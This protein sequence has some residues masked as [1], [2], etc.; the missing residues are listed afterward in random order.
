MPYLSHNGQQVYYEVHGDQGP[1]LVALRGLGR[2]IRH[3]LG[4]EQE[5]AKHFRVIMVELRGIGQSQANHGLTDT[6]Y[7]LAG[8]VAAVVK[9]INAQPAHILGVSL[10][11]MV[12]IALA[13]R[14]P[15]ICRSLITVNTSIAGQRSMRMSI[16]AVK[17]LGGGLV[18]K[19]SMEKRLVD[20]LVGRDF[21]EERKPELE[22][23]YNEIGAEYGLPL[24]TVIR[25]LLSAA[26]FHPKKDLGDL[27]VPALVIYGTHD[28][29]T[30]NI[31]S[32]KLLRYLPKA[33]V[34][35]ID[36]GGHELSVDKPKELMAALLEWEREMNANGGGVPASD[37]ATS[38]RA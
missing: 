7:D 28:R 27:Q 18:V 13:L 6:M 34:V 24:A 25:Q 15:E 20:V 36:G 37:E 2:S 16:N 32:K 38:I 14:H 8:D 1:W 12:A 9:E 3:W 29:F 11:G 22:A 35:A 5:M 23:A 4:Y 26:R 21:P 17:A 31:N 33:K 30:P 19:G 10:G